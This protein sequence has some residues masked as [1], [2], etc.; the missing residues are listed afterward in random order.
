M[1]WIGPRSSP[2]ISGVRIV[3]D[4]LLDEQ[5]RVA[6]IVADLFHCPDAVRVDRRASPESGYRALH[7]VI[8]RDGLLAEIQIR[9]ELHP[10]RSSTWRRT[11]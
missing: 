1:D 5:A 2:D 3:G 10:V 9:T 4:L 6:D 8:T 11:Y 7:V